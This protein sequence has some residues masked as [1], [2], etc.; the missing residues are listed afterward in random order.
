MMTRLAKF[1]HG[2]PD[3]ESVIVISGDKDFARV[4]QEAEMQGHDFYVFAP[5]SNINR[6]WRQRSNA[7]ILDFNANAKE[8]KAYDFLRRYLAT[9]NNEGRLLDTEDEDEKTAALF[10]HHVVYG[11]KKTTRQMDFAAFC[12]A[13]RESLPAPLKTLYRKDFLGN[14]VHLLAS[15]TDI[16]STKSH[17]M[18][19]GHPGTLFS[20]NTKSTVLWIFTGS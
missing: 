19:N 17:F 14:I 11:I 3:I 10:L 18:K 13:I 12:N 7:R 5:S 16:V 20:Y 6:G 2:H 8:A 9:I 4:K 15:D 1:C